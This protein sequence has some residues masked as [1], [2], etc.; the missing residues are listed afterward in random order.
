MSAVC[1][2]Y[3]AITSNRPYK[4]GWDPA[5]A[6]RRMAS[7]KGH[8]DPVVLKAFI[9]SLG[10]YPA[11]SLVRLSS[12]RLAVVLEQR[13]GDL[14]RPLVRVFY[15]ARLRSH[16][17]LADVDLSAPGCSERITGIESPREWGFRDLH[18]L[19]AP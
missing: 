13:P 10:I 4:E 18:K 6:L 15:S 12:D 16:L 17:L 8:F 3:D 1:D 11:G 7:W 5:E 19:W 14:T 9:A 2:V